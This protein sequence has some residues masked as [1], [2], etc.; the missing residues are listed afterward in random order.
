MHAAN[1]AAAT[2]VHLFALVYNFLLRNYSVTFSFILLLMDIWV[3]FSFLLLTIVLLSFLL[4]MWVYMSSGI[5]VQAFHLFSYLSKTAVSKVCPYSALVMPIIFWSRA[6]FYP[7]S[8][9]LLLC[10]LLLV[11]CA[12][13]L[14]AGVFIYFMVFRDEGMLNDSIFTVWIFS[15]NI[16]NFCVYYYY[17]CQLLIGLPSFLFTDQCFPPFW[18]TGLTWALA[19]P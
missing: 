14:L 19:P 3:V 15:P 4:R 13:L 5:A 10:I 16:C 11:H 2:V 18:N 9:R 8:K 7:S 12:C 6:N 17:Y 1:V